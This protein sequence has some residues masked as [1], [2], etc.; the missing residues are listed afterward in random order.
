MTEGRDRYY[1]PDGSWQELNFALQLIADRLDRFEGLR[2]YPTFYQEMFKFPVGLTTGKVLFSS[3]E[4]QA[5]F[6]SPEE[7]GIVTGGGTTTI[8]GSHLFENGVIFSIQDPNGT[9]IHQF[10]IDEVPYFNDFNMYLWGDDSE[11]ITDIDQNLNPE[12]SPYFDDVSVNRISFDSTESLTPNTGELTWNADDGTLN[13]G[14]LNDV[15]L[16]LGQEQHYYPKNVSGAQ[17]DN[18]AAVMFAGTIGAS[19]KLQVDLAQ[20]DVSIPAEYF[21]GLATQDI[22][23]NDFGY[24]TGFGLVRGID[25]TGT[26]VGEVWNDGDL[27][28]LSETPGELTLTPP[29]SPNPKILAAA[30]VYAHATIGSLFVRPTWG[31]YLSSLHDVYISGIADNDILIWDDTNQ[32]WANSA[33]IIVDTVTVNESM[34]IAIVDVNGTII[35]QYNSDEIP[36][37]NDFNGYLWGDDIDLTSDVDQ[38]LYVGDSPSFSSVVLAGTTGEGIKVDHN[39]PTYPWQDLIGEIVIR[40]VAATDPSFATYIGNIRQYQFGTGDLVTNNFHIL[41]NHAPGY[42]Y[43]IHVH[44]SHISTLV[45]SGSVTWSFEISYAK[46]HDQAAFPSPK[47]ITVTQN[48]STTQYQHMIA[49]VAFTAETAD[50]THFDRDDIEVDGVIMVATSLTA[51]T[52]NAATDPFVHYIDIH[53]QSISS[54]TK[55]KAPNFYVT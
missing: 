41:H 6:V 49:E 42:D 14:L 25:T 54:G 43:Y 29:T 37:F 2:D 35:H 19:G 39:T 32:R 50:A 17:I 11:L 3:A 16:Q 40:G 45:T 1:V 23:N 5:E 13:V 38:N 24:V 53:Y 20:S 55:N 48:A 12:D 27:L 44:W 8:T 22:A 15:V 51:N 33:D 52:L 4:N 47:T 36:Y 7:A 10:N 30:V 31:D 46:G 18:G 21:M 26:P 34:L 28:Y 9:I